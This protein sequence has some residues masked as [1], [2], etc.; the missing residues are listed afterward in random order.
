MTAIENT[1]SD[2]VTIQTILRVILDPIDTVNLFG[3]F[4]YQIT[5]KDADGS[6]DIPSQG[7]INIVNNIDK[8][9]TTGGNE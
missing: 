8:D 6:V 2:G 9:F 3:K 7:I 1:L 5:I 4:V